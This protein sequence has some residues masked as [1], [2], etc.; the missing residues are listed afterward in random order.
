[1]YTKFYINSWQAEIF[2]QTSFQFFSHDCVTI[3]FSVLTV[4]VVCHTMKL[5]WALLLLLIASSVFAKVIFPTVSH[6]YRYSY[7]LQFG[8]KVVK[9][10]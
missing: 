7:C 10:T 1:M 2:K 5:L 4:F 6:I 8:T 3:T 9:Y